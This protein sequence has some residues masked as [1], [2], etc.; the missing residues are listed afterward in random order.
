MIGFALLTAGFWFAG[1]AFVQLNLY[2]FSIYPKLLSCVRSRGCC[3]TTRA[4]GR[5]WSPRWPAW[6]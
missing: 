4:A 2:R 1:E 3:G 6:P 5:M